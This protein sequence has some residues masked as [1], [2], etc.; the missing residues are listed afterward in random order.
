V[1]ATPS[2]LVA[3]ATAAQ[4]ELAERSNYGKIL[5]DVAG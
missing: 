2:I 3:E 5:L 1:K 4:H